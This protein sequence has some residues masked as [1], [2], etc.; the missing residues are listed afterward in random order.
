MRVYQTKAKGAQEAHEAIR[1]AG[2]QMRPADQLP[3]D[4]KERDLYDLIWKRTVATQM[5][6][7][8]LKFTTATI[9]VEDAVFRASG[10]VVLFPGFF[11]AYVEGSDDPEA[12][13]ENQESPLP[14]LQQD[15][16][17]DCRELEAIGHETKPPA[18]YTEA[19]LVK[20]L[21]A[22]GVGRPSTYA[23][24]IDTI[25][26]RNYVFK[27][28]RELVPTFTAFAVTI[29]LENHFEELVDLQFTAEMEQKL[30]DIAAGQ[31]DWLTYL[32]TFFL[33][34]NGLENQVKQKESGIDPRIASGLGFDDLPAEIR[35]GQFGPFLS[36]EENGERLTAGLPDKLPPADLTPEMA[37]E[38]LHNKAD[39][40]N[41]LGKHPEH[42]L[43]VLLQ[44]GAV[45]SIRAIGRRRRGG[46]AA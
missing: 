25:Q 2:D 34:E 32:R 13:L 31:M 35:I 15:E 17:V 10:R 5:A 36:K 43:S 42:D 19:T 9:E 28:R 7:A 11:R 22:E 38:L 44:A 14:D 18:R 39:G 4:G 26:R 46:K 29:L 30:D 24:I 12:A 45:W 33:G 6:N 21:E 8:R 1:P 37:E 40:P 3:I 20:A 27:Q 41:V 16:E 23:S